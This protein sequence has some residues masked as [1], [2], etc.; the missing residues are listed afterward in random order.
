M[1]MNKTAWYLYV[2]FVRVMV[3]FLCITILTWM[4]PFCLH[5][6]TFCCLISDKMLV[7]IYSVKAQNSEMMR[8]FLTSPTGPLTE[9][10]TISAK[11]LMSITSIIIIMVTFPV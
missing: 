3:R 6:L 8:L 4:C 9:N 1:T 5:I 2:L 11:S 10:T 7:D